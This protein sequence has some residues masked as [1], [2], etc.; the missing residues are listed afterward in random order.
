MAIN[1]TPIAVYDT[2]VI[3]QATLNPAG[4][5]ERALARVQL[6]HVVAVMSDRLRSEYEQ[7]LQR[8][9]LQDKYPLLQNARLVEAQFLRVDTY[10]RRVSN[11]PKRISYQRDPNDEHII[12]LVIHIQA[13][14]LV[15]RDNDLLDLNHD[16]VFRNLCQTTEVVDPVDFLRQMERRG[17]V[18]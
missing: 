1:S 3:L 18:A 2:G 15:T 10:I 16:P 11:P 17:P 4:P 12:N 7:T 9:D 13:D 14:Y 8:D 6:R 5:A